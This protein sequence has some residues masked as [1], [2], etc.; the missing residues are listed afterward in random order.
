MPFNISDFKSSVDKFGGLARPSLFEVTLTKTREV[1]S[2]IENRDL[3]FFCTQTNF[4]GINFNISTMEQV[5]QRSKFF[6]TGVLSEP[7]STMF[8]V[9]S[10]HQVLTFFHNWMQ[11][12]VNYSSKSGTNGA[13]GNELDLQR[14]F[15]VGYK[16]DYTCNMSIKHYS[17]ESA[18]NKFYE[19]V[20]E[21]VFPSMI[22]DLDLSWDNNDQFIRLPVVF[23]YDHLSYSGD[24]TGKQTTSNG[25]GILETLGDL[26]GF[27]DVVSQTFSQGRPTSIQDAVNRLNR[28]QNA[29]G[30]MTSF[31][32]DTSG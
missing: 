15:E 28:V 3:T 27:V 32:D 24:R 18:G 17:T 10:D 6:P 13:I 23:M 9:D 20:F 16:S 1:N 2:R 22:G 31:L 21:N 5:G 8:L 4:P 11:K 7:V 26:A 12:V 25:R 19:V 30:N 14:P 29:Y